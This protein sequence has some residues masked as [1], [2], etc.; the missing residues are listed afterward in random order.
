MAKLYL[1]RIAAALLPRLPQWLVYGGAWLTGEIAYR[2]AAGPRRAVTDNLRH[3]LGAQASSQELRRAVRGVFRTSVYNYV[4]LFRLPSLPPAVLAPRV[5]IL[6]INHFLEVYSKGKGVIIA[7][8]HLG[9][10]DLLVQLSRERNISVTLLVEPLEPEALFDLV[11]SLR[12]SHGIQLVPVGRRGLGV[13]MKTLREGGVLA[14]ALDR[15]IQRK[16]TLVDFFG[17]PARL[18]QGAVEL[19]RRTGAAIVPIFGLRLPKH[20]YRMI[21]EPPFVMSADT[22]EEAVRQDV[23]RL[24]T[25]LER[26]VAAY[27]DQWIVFEHVW[28]S[29]EP[30]MTEEPPVTAESAAAQK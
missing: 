22:S 16:G 11:C 17:A 8:G 9:N 25:V 21:V 15:D 6:D 1:F 10:F 13:A 24:T 3:V 27:P 26:Q 30:R 28:D 2:V 14:V 23:Q 20:R 7:T 19:A 4:D 12:S 29:D 18:P 5:E